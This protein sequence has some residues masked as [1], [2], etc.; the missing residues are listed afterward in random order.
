MAGQD[1]LPTP[2]TG[3]AGPLDITL[4]SAIES[5]PELRA[6]AREFARANGVAVPDDVALAV[7]E[8]CTNVVMHAYDDEDADGWLHLTGRL[9]GELLYLTVGDRGHGM[10]SRRRSSGLGLGLAIMSAASKRLRIREATTGTE[11]ELGFEIAG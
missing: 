3:E 6:A 8:A 9:D 2:R 4:P 1:V 11:V 10:R 5:V 7:S